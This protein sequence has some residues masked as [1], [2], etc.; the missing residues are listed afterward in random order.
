MTG[1]TISHFRVLGKLGAGGMG[2]V[3]EAEDTKLGRKV[4]IKFLS[5]KIAN[6]T[7]TVERFE[8]EARAASALNHPN[9]CT[10]YE[11]DYFEGQPFMAMELLEGETLNARLSHGRMEIVEI[12]RLGA[13]IADALDAAHSHGIVHR[14]IKPANVFITTRGTGKVLDFG[15]AKLAIGA[16]GDR[17]TGA[18]SE[19]LT[20]VTGLTMPGIAMGTAAYMSPEQARGEQLDGRTDLFSLG[21]VLYEMT[22]GR[23]P[24]R[25]SNTVSILSAILS[26]DPGQPSSLN[27]G[28]PQEL[29]RIISTAIKKDRQLRY[30]TPSD[31]RADL[32]RLLRQLET[33]A[34]PIPMKSWRK[35]PAMFVVVALLLG[36]GALLFRQIRSR[37]P[38]SNIRVSSTAS[39]PSRRSVAVLGFRNLTAKPEV[40]WLSTAL[41]EMLSTELGVGEHL[42]ILSRVPGCVDRPR[43][44]G[45]NHRPLKCEHI[46]VSIQRR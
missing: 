17:E 25:G 24:F 36:V 13:E 35:A 27:P 8:R 23:R 29:D 4:A 5:E 26:E 2:V 11:I 22:A 33:G 31:L 7:Q 20:N 45:Q 28:V 10:V 3:F 40:A 41:S 18:N 1:R 30:Q 37:Q 19:T 12:L 14:D 9:I 38:S 6:G 46:R 32:S 42:R 34:T 39:I 44:P 16:S 21:V 43:R 15:L